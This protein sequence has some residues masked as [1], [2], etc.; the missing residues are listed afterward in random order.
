[1]HPAL[2]GFL[3]GAALAL[4][5]IIFEYS[6]IQR[7]IAEKSKRMAKKIDWDSNQISRMRGMITFGIALPIGVALI[8]WIMFG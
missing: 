2:Q 3:A 8:A 7:E 5:L 1:M 4:I 6:A